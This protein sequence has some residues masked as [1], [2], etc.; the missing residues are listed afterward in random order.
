VAV[1]QT[2]L[3]ERAEREAREK[4]GALE[5]AVE[6][7]TRE[8]GAAVAAA[9]VAGEA[10]ARDLEALIGQLNAKDRELA[11]LRAGREREGGAAAKEIEALR[12]QL[13]EVRVGCGRGEG[14][15]GAG[16]Q[17]GRRRSGLIAPAVASSNPLRSPSTT[18]H[19]RFLTRR[20]RRRRRT[21]PRRRTRRSRRRATPRPRRRRTRRPRRAAPWTT[22]RWR[23]CA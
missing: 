22:R 14:W 10:H 18:P 8:L 23:S 13:E 12:A 20:P 19:P 15:L 16:R 1:R 4:L 17:R 5:A 9:S 7:K 21:R 6:A 2:R 11:A 3:R